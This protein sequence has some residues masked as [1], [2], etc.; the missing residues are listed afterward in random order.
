MDSGPAHGPG[1]VQ[2]QHP[3][4]GFGGEAPRKFTPSVKT[5]LHLPQ[6]KFVSVNLACFLHFIFS[7]SFVFSRALL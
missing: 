1:E 3:A 7:R 2:G 6:Q 5:G 4:G